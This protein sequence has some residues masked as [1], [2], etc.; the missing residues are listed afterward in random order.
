MFELTRVDK[1]MK[2]GTHPCSYA[3]HWYHWL[4][5]CKLKY[6]GL[7]SSNFSALSSDFI[8][9]ATQSGVSKIVHCSIISNSKRKKKS[10]GQSRR[11]SRGDQLYELQCNHVSCYIAIENNVV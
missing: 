8:C 10:M 3:K 9:T 5:L 11:Q 4:I 1:G 2:T 6:A 7:A